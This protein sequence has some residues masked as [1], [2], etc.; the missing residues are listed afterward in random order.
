MNFT[1]LVKAAIE[2]VAPIHVF[3][4]LPRG[5]EVAYDIR[6]SLPRYRVETVFDVGANVGQS[7]RQ[8]LRSF[9][10]SHIYCFEPVQDTF[11][12]LQ[13]NLTGNNRVRC[14]RLALG[15]SRGKGQMVVRKLS[16]TSSF[17]RSDSVTEPNESTEDVDIATLE[18]FCITAKVAHVSYL[19]IDTEGSDLDVLRGG[20]S[21]LGEQR[22]D[23]VE[24]EASMHPGNQWHVR[25]ESLKDYLESKNYLLF[26]IYTQKSEVPSTGPHLRRTNTTFISR[27]MIDRHRR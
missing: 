26:G 14:A 9:P 16:L 8:Y 19:K 2:R 25:F 21:L 4:T 1:S 22:I 5:M 23:F 11:R 15:A 24:V 18:D 6:H 13:E 7:A 12:Q 3:R 17:V 27:R 20:E 10:D